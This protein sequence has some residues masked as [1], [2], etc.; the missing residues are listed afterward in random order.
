M[1]NKISK[2]VNNIFKINLEVKKSERVLVFTDGYNKE[3]RKIGKLFT[4]TGSK[5]AKEI[6]YI[7]HSS[8]NCHGV[9]PP[10]EIWAEAFGFNVYRKLKQE[11][12]L[13]PLLFKKISGK[14]LKAVE[15]I[16][17]THK[18]EAVNAVIAL[19]YFS[20]T[21]TRFRNF[22]NR[23][24]GTRYVSMPLFDEPMLT[25]AISVNLKRMIERTKYIA[26]KLNGCD[27]IEIK[28]PNGTFLTLY[29]K[30]R[31]AQMDTGIITKPG[32]F[33]NLPAGEVFLAP[34]EGSAKGKLV[35]NWASTRKLKNPI[36]LQIAKGAVIKVEGTE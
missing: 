30:G 23:I 15:N 21:H 24:C 5:F 8:T 28:T 20:T 10:E 22:L 29:K 16:V 27:Q 4:K 18:R 33:S 34:L 31:K 11:K 26:K 19:S 13:K 1:K 2:A 14:K 35:L 25:G 6:K 12:L 3:I 9:E 7:E 36:T 32:S 17:A